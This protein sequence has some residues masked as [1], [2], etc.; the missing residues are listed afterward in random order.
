MGRRAVILG[1]DEALAQEI[2]E[3]LEIEGIDPHLARNSN[4]AFDMLDQEDQAIS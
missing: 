4:D 1:L 2:G 3:T